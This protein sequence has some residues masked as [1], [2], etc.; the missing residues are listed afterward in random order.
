MYLQSLLP[1]QHQCTCDPT[2]VDDDPTLL[3]IL[4][5]IHL[6]SQALLIGTESRVTSM[7]L[8]HRYFAKYTHRFVQFI[9][10]DRVKTQ[11]DI[12]QLIFNDPLH[13]KHLGTVASAC[14]FLACKTENETKKI[15]DV[16][17]LSH[18]LDFQGNIQRT[19]ISCRDNCTFHTTVPIVEAASPPLLDEQYWEAK[20]VLV[21]TEQALLRFISYDVHV[22]HPHRILVLCLD[23]LFLLVNQKVDMMQHLRI[24]DM[25]SLHVYP[26][27]LQKAWR[28]INDTLFYPPCLR[29]PTLAVVA[30]S[31][32]L[33]IQ[34][35][36]DEERRRDDDT[37]K[38]QNENA[39]TIVF[40][41]T[42]LE[43]ENHIWRQRCSR[44]DL[45]MAMLMVQQAMM[46]KN[47]INKK[48]L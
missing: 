30:V 16:V 26:S 2:L 42:I 12:Q 29:L 48:V 40:L 38:G 47:I 3:D 11:M 37:A 6:A 43:K 27:L 39:D 9:D 44:N 23:H 28:I 14:I 17:N 13:R 20:Q 46:C 21:S 33:A 34:E 18:M 7:V 19:S 4:C 22:S 24:G 5:R 10:P 41:A 15:R 32:Q 1:P 36:K 25:D 45:D 35:Y 31:I 8:F